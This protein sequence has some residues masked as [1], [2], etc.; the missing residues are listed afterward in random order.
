[1][2]YIRSI[3]PLLKTSKPPGC[4]CRQRTAAPSPVVPQADARLS[5]RQMAS[6]CP[7]SPQLRWSEAFLTGPLIA[8]ARQPPPPG[9]WKQVLRSTLARSCSGTSTRTSA[10]HTRLITFVPHKKSYLN[11]PAVGVRALP[12]SCGV[13]TDH[14]GRVACF[15]LGGTQAR[16]GKPAGSPRLRRWRNPLLVV[17]RTLW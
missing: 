3:A 6:G 9:F 5:L 14:R 10:V 1:M 12:H 8:Y 2:F 16:A 7:R 4:R 17:R 15:L 13:R 11:L